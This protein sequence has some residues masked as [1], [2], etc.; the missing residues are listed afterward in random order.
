MMDVYSHFF[1]LSQNYTNMSATVST[2]TT[3]ITNNTNAITAINTELDAL[4]KMTYDSPS[5]TTIFDSRL[6]CQRDCF[7]ANTAYGTISL[8]ENRQKIVTIEGVNTTQNTNI[9]TNTTNISTNTT[10]I[11]TNTAN[12]STNTTN[13]ST[14]TANISTNTSAIS[15]IQ[16]VNNTQNTNISTNTTNISTNAAAIS[17]IQTVNITQ[18]NDITGIKALD[19]VQDTRITAVEDNAYSTTNVL[20][21]EEFMN[22]I[23]LTA[24]VSD[25]SSLQWKNYSSVG[26][27]ST[28]MYTDL[29]QL[30]H[31]GI[32]QL[33]LPGT[34]SFANYQVHCGLT[35]MIF[36][37]DISST[38]IIFKIPSG[39]TSTNFKVVVGVS[40]SN[41]LTKSAVWTSTNNGYF[42]AS[43]NNGSVLKTS[44]KFNFSVGNWIMS[45]TTRTATG[46]IMELTQPNNDITSSKETYTY[47]GTG[48]LSTDLI[49]P[50]IA[51]Y[52]ITGNLYTKNILLDYISINLKPLRNNT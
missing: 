52:E 30:G 42:K 14:N 3:N 5:D 48:I 50:W 12:I 17:A 8:V 31:P 23:S 6:W 9:S 20:L 7:V 34:P 49:S 47:T 13:I 10:N 36:W 1:T 25:T 33:Y 15:V 16:G 44:T 19:I 26:N 35:N 38:Q 39:L 27:A 4:T 22:P 43:V 28:K 29:N 51:I 32:L 18:S 24:G 46:C 37:G 40:N 2:N 21:V 41:A 45:T 11:S